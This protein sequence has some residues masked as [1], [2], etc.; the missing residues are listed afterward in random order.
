MVVVQGRLVC[1]GS[2]Q[3]LKSTFGGAYRLEI[4]GPEGQEATAAICRVV[5]DSFPGAGLEE[6]HFGHL[7]FALPAE[8]LS[9][10][11]VF[12]VED[13]IRDVCHT[14]NVHPCPW[15]PTVMFGCCLAFR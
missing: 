3:H 6:D 2:P 13:N 5:G 8:G 11:R 1:L 10:A 15:I 14:G 12:K 9:L 4:H 7:K